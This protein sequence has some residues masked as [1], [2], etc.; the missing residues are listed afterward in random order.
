MKALAGW[1]AAPAALV[2]T[3]CFPLE[4]PTVY[5]HADAPLWPY[6]GSVLSGDFCF[7]SGKIGDRGGSFEAEATSALD[8]VEQELGRAGLT[9]RQ[10]VQ[11]TVYL[12]DI[13][14]YEAF[15]EV[16]AARVPEP[17]PARAVVQVA[18]L[19]GDA[20]VEIQATAR[21]R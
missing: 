14:N 9:L 11:V 2:L 21:R 3:A 15:N 12:T 16:Y 7:V 17:Y 18:A 10:L 5:M 4:S 1:M 13:D 20:R 8:A 19:P 6:S